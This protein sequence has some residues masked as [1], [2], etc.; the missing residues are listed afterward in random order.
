[1]FENHNSQNKNESESIIELKL[2]DGK[3]YAKINLKNGGSIQE[4]KLGNTILIKDLKPLSYKDTY[5]STILFPFAG[6]IKN[7]EY[8]FL[9]KQ[10]RLALNDI[11]KQNALHGL[12]Y[13]KHFKVKEMLTTKSIAQ[14]VLEYKQEE[15]IEGFP[16]Q[17][18]IQL[19]YILTNNVLTF[20]VKVFNTGNL[21]FPFSLG[22]HPYF[23]SS[24]LYENILSLNSSKKITGKLNISGIVK[25][26]IPSKNVVGMVEGTDPKLKDEFVIYSA[27]YDHIGIGKPNAENDSIYNGARDNA[28]GT[29][30]VLSAAENIAKYPTKRSA[31]F[32]LITAE[33]KGLLGSAYYVEKY[34]K[35]TLPLK[36][37]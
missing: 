6:R 7:G 32:I 18:S 28:V 4:L 26:A 1:M 23:S 12:V 3:S 34:D 13:N 22:W 36:M 10:Y 25:K 5:A 27:H 8:N 20:K 35:I 14:V 17:F 24:N 30:T 16:F 21:P 29:V 37:T 33:E 15:L 19:N 9:N 31:L 2:V 11:K